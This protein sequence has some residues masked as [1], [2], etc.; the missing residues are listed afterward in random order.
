MCVSAAGRFAR[1]FFENALCHQHRAVAVVA[2]EEPP[3]ALA[4]EDTG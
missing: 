2:V 4:D 3:D 1:E